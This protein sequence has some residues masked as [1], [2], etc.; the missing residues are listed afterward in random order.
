MAITDIQISEELQ[1]NAPSIKYRGNEGP[2]SPQEMM[3][4]SGGQPL[5]EDPTKPVNP[6][7]PKPTG[8]VLPNKMAFDDTPVFELRSL[9]LLIDEFREDHNGEGPKSIDDLRR[10][11]YTKYGPEGIAKV[12]EATQEGRE[13]AAY[14]GIMGA[15]GRRQYGIGSWFQKAKDKLVD[16]LIPNEI[17]E[18]PL[19]TAALIGTGA[20][21]IDL[22]PGGK[23]STGWI[24]DAIDTIKQSKMGQSVKELL[25]TETKDNSTLGKDI[26][27][28]IAK[29]ILPIAGGIVSG[30][31]TNNQSGQPG[32]PSDNTALQ[33]E[34]LKKSANL[35]NQ[36]QG[37]A[38]G[39]NFL[40]AVSARKFTPEEMAITYAQALPE[41]TQKAAMGGRIG[42]ANG[43]GL[44]DLGGM[45][46]DYRN[47][48]GFVPIGKA[49][50]ADDVPA[51]LSVNE[52]VFTADAVRNAGGGDIDKGAEVM[53]NV[54]KHLEGGGQISQESQGLG[55]A[56]E[57]FAT[58][59]RLSE[60]I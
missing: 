44:M 6:F 40:P 39:L 24:G 38:A 16:D 5:P 19:L 33:L 1:T 10:F 22:I 30:L 18:N 53:E 35:L 41:N 15:D 21:Y 37:M 58:S 34:D 3:M 48:G 36:Q 52:F 23:D 54:M 29:N 9:E 11:F 27:G 26:K 57:M 12:D 55:G 56:R 60:V 2:K 46:K 43:G 45:E 14:G 17:K 7:A 51:R 49:E 42:F 8:P 20:N 32:L 28:S 50:K 4:R 25:E 31:F 47:E 13:T 59:E